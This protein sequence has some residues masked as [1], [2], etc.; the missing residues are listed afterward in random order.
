[1]E[2]ETHPFEP[3][4]PGNARLLML[5]T[6]PP[7][8]KRWCMKFYYPNFT[9]DMWRIFGL[10]FFGDKFHFVRQEE[11]TYDLDS[12]IPFLQEKGIAMYDTA[13]RIIRTTGT[14]SDKDLQIVEETDL[15]QMLRQLPLCRV[16]LTAGQLATTVACRQFAIEEPGVGSYK[17]F[18][19]HSSS[20]TPSDNDEYR[21]YRMPSSSRAYPMSVE[22]KAEAYMNVFKYLRLL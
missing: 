20:A 3:F 1:M 9:N 12:I 14:A 19:L 15:C 11:K 13:T 5:G 2:T 6:F 18:S 7:A 4:L 8:E 22:R 10:C 17:Q 21:L 16:V